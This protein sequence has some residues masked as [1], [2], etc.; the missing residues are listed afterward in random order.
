MEGISSSP[1][2]N[3]FFD[4]VKEL[5]STK[6]MIAGHDHDNDYSIVYEGIRLTYA[7]KVG[8]GCYFTEDMM[9]GTTLTIGSDPEGTINQLYYAEKDGVWSKVQ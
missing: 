6:H 7:V 2:N 3:G 1:V 5:G 8:R 4:V 9:G